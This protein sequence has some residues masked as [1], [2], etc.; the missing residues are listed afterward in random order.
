MQEILWK[1]IF[2]QATQKIK[3]RM[4]AFQQNQQ[5]TA[6]DFPVRTIETTC[7]NCQ[8]SLKFSNSINFLP[9]LIAFCNRLSL[10]S[11]ASHHN[12]K[13]QPINEIP[14]DNYHGNHPQWLYLSSEIIIQDQF[15]LG[16]ITIKDLHPNFLLWHISE[17][18][19]V[20]VWLKCYNFL[21]ETNNENYDLLKFSLGLHLNDKITR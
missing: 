12:L 21:Y 4:K 6:T 20:I 8:L 5:P 19:D 18:P 2:W 9:V 1:P 15:M 7:P 17:I 3:R 14:N 13:L 16:P 10:T 11:T